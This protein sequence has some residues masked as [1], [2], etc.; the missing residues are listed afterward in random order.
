MTLIDLLNFVLGLA[1]FITGFVI[2]LQFFQYRELS[3]LKIVNNLWLLGMFGLLLGVSLWLQFFLPF[4]PPEAVQAEY[5][6]LLQ[7]LAGAAA[8]ALFYFY[9][10]RLLRITN[11]RYRRW[12]ATSF[13]LVILWL[14]IFMLAAV[15][16]QDR[17]EWLRSSMA[18]ANYL[19]GLP[20]VLL[21]ALA[22][23]SQLHQF[24]HEAEPFLNHC[25]HGAIACLAVYAAITMVRIPYTPLGEFFFGDQTANLVDILLQVLLALCGLVLSCFI[26][27][28]MQIFD[29]EN[30]R[31]LED[32]QRKQAIL[33]ERLRIGR[34]LHDGVIQSIY[35]TG[36]Q[37]EQALRKLDPASPAAASLVCSLQDMDRVIED[38]RGYIMKLSPMQEETGG[39]TRAL[40]SLFTE[41]TRRSGIPADVKFIGR[42]DG[43]VEAD[44]FHH[45]YHVLKEALANITR[46]A[47]AGTVEA[48]IE[49]RPGEL[50]CTLRDDGIGLPRIFP[51]GGYGLRNIRDRVACLG[52]EVKWSSEPKKGTELRI[53]LPLGVRNHAIADSG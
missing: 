37:I 44:V 2:M 13:F 28:I 10:A 12:Q 1:Y 26:L 39:P 51:L 48:M 32:A 11:P 53:R 27:R 52:G 17:Q 42:L 40:Q 18:W 46:H 7:V 50:H 15:Y 41:F 33:Q 43:A 36:L 21:V 6:M 25:L 14:A 5:V 30:C 20:G 31:K 35:G 16:Y 29:L 4:L 8:Y 24:R 3:E 49:V 34:D 47:R 45:L 38:I 23:S 19:L 9:G 22:F